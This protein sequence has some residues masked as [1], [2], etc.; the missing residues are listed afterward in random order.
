MDGPYVRLKTQNQIEMFTRDNGKDGQSVLGVGTIPFS[1]DDVANVLLDDSQRKEFDEMLDQGTIL[2]QYDPMTF[3]IYITFKRVLILSPRD[4]LLCGAFVKFKDGTYIFPT[5]SIDRD[6][7][8]ETKEF[9]RAKLHIGGWVLQPMGPDKTIA[10]YYNRADMKG[11]I[12][13]FI[14]KQGASMQAQ[15]VA[16]LR[17]HMKK[18]KGIK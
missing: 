8:P 18:K 13:A 9:I 6:D 3:V 7:R 17:D 11:S 5:I 10:Y 15:M 16:K 2:N 12:P 1:I 4:F 14:M